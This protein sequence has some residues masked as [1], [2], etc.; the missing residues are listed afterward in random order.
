[1]LDF[2]I[3]VFMKIQSKNLE[4]VVESFADLPGIGKKSALRLAL[5]LLS[6]QGDKIENFRNALALLKHIQRCEVCYNI[7]DHNLCAICQDRNRKSSVVCVVENIEDVMAIEETGQYRGTYHVLGGVISPIEGIGP[8]DLQIDGLIERVA[9]GKVEE[10]IMAISPTID[11]ET[12]IYY[13]TRKLDKYPVTVSQIARGVAFGGELQ[14]TDEITLGRSILA[15]VPYL[16]NG[17]ST[18]SN[19]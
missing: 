2:R 6:D 8:E 3:F 16:I 4:Q 9:L 12:T 14:Y 17:G 1:M 10:I 19:G 13:I 5:H 15:R 18:D 7:S 11:G